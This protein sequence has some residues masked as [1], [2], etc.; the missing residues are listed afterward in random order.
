MVG[1]RQIPTHD[2]TMS[3]M[4]LSFF[5]VVLIGLLCIVLGLII[6]E[7]LKWLRFKVDQW[8]FQRPIPVVQEEY[9]ER[10]RRKQRRKYRE[11]DFDYE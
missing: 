5:S 2:V 11:D 8:R 3:P 7:L 4:P 10:P 9:R 6:S 1:V